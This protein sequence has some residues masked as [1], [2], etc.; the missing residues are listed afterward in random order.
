MGAE[1]AELMDIND[2]LNFTSRK[3]RT[4]KDHTIQSMIRKEFSDLL[5]LIEK[6]PMQKEN[7][8]KLSDVLIIFIESM[9]NH[10]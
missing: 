10:R 5:C 2:L 8:E 4:S 3:L 1:S 7:L 9:L 6:D